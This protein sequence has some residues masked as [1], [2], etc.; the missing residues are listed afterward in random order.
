MVDGEG[1]YTKIFNDKCGSI[2][3][4]RFMTGCQTKMG[5]IWKLNIALSIPLLLRLIASVEEE[6][7][8]RND[9]EEE[10]MWIVFVTYDVVSYIISLGA[11]EDF[12]LDLEGLNEN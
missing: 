9:K 10:Y 12:L 8:E 4:E 1:I 6:I 2:W 11:N 3:F 5:G 7:G